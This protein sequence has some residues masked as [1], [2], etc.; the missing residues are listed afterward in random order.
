MNGAWEARF[1][2]YWQLFY[3]MVWAT[4]DR[5]PL[6]T[7]ETEPVV[8]DFLRAKAIGLGAT[9]FALNGTEDHVHMVA[10]IPPVISVSRFVGQVKAV[11]S[12]RFNKYG[13]T[14]ER[15]SW[16]NEYGVFSLDRKRLRDHIEYVERQKEHHTAR[17]VVPVLERTRGGGTELEPGWA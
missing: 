8:Y 13:V 6:L 15:F 5:E 4:K 11:A 3:H 9:V 7:A 2:P 10:S 17:R 14:G 1:M 16:Q 12:A